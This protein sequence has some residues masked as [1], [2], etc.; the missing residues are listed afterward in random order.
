[1]DTLISL[2]FSDELKTDPSDRSVLYT[3]PTNVSK[4]QREKMMQVMM[5][6]TGVEK[7]VG[8]DQCFLTMCSQGC[9]PCPLFSC[10]PADS[11]AGLSALCLFL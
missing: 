2:T 7:C 1:M 6:S 5:E 4:A 9:L 10:A 11:L 3:E 8:M